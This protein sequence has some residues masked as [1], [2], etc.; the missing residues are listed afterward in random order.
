MDKATLD[1]VVA[2]DSKSTNPFRND[3]N[4]KPIH[5]RYHQK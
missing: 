4:G 5:Y 1:S 3:V 2:E